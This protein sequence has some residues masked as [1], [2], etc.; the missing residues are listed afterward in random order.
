MT[1]NISHRTH[2]RITET[3]GWLGVPLNRVLSF[4]GALLVFCLLAAPRLG[5]QQASSTSDRTV[6]SPGIE[7]ELRAM[8]EE[9]HA[10]RQEVGSLRQELHDGV[11]GVS[12][13]SETSPTRQTAVI[14]VSRRELASSNPEAVLL[15]RND[16]SEHESLWQ[17]DAA[18]V[19]RYTTASLGSITPN[20]GAGQKYAEPS[21][22]AN[23]PQQPAD[24]QSSDLAGTVSMLQS[25]VA[26]QAQT[27]VESNT[28][29]GV[30]LFG[31]ILSTTFFNSGA[32][33][34][35]DIPSVVNWA[36]TVPSS[37]GSFSSSM[38]Q[39]RIGLVVD[40]PAIGSMHASGYFA[41]DFLGGAADFQ[42]GPLFG[43]P[44]VVY[45]YV[46]L[47][48]AKTSLEAGQD[49]IILAS[50]HPTSLVA[51]SFPELFRSGDLYDRAPQVRVEREL[52]SNKRGSL[53]ATVGLVAPVANYPGL[54]FPGAGLLEAWQRPAIQ[55]RLAWRPA[56]AA[57]SANSGFEFGVSAHYGTVQLGTMNFVKGVPTFSPLVGFG[58]TS[59][60][61]WAG[62]ID[63]DAHIHRFGVDGSAYLGQN[64]QS[65]GGGIGQPG[66]TMG[67]Y[68]EGRFAATNRLQFNSGFG[69]DHL[70]KFD[71]VPVDLNRNTSVFANTIFQFTP[72]VAASFE[73]RYLV[74]RPFTGVLRTNN[75]VDVGIAYSF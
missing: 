33:D 38:R 35:A 57:S 11:H 71:I 26:E 28:K 6:T 70:T 16:S 17:K 4:A 46:R 58:A 61:S 30:K 8:R 7:D 20:P 75:H 50:R 65:F 72:E 55:G 1:S 44:H 69:T 12:S 43:L 34:W 22:P 66:K 60:A 53:R 32:A 31:T 62:L 19:R 45:G 68:L 59:A 41:V 39:S 10:L 5:A 74:T 27:K 37:T 21:K 40:G 29:M 2:F 3:P 23:P 49:E 52:A 64:L 56:E 73:Y 24:E 47:D 54:D 15:G 25:Q 63:F 51:M 36:A 42:S 9:I 14:P 13:A 67:G 48:G 18:G